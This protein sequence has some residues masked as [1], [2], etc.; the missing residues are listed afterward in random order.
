MALVGRELA[1]HAAL[2]TLPLALAPVSTMLMTIPA[3]WL[4]AP[5]PQGGVCPSAISGMLGGLVGCA[6]LFNGDFVYM[7][8]GPWASVR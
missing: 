1:P 8:V 4:T 5:R 7:C 3:L 2:A 6:G